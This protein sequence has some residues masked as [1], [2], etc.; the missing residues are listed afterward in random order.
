M[1]T[2]LLTD[3]KQINEFAA[4]L[5]SELYQLLTYF[6][7]FKIKR[8][9][10]SASKIEA[11]DN[12]LGDIGSELGYLSYQ[13]WSFMRKLRAADRDLNVFNH[14]M[15]YLGWLDVEFHRKQ[16]ELYAAYPVLND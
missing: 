15:N 8:G 10:T 6:N 16:N 4:S 13:Y 11:L 7:E 12:A 14:I 5:K 3:E 9:L 2:R 1:A